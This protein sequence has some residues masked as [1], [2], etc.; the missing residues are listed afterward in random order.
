MCPSLFTGAGC[1]PESTEDWQEHVD[2]TGC[3]NL[4]FTTECT[5]GIKKTNISELTI[6]PNPTNDLLTI[7]TKHRTT[8]RSKSP[9]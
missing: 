1:M 5:I 9:P 4:Y 3:P 2:T 7:E 6:Y 8:I